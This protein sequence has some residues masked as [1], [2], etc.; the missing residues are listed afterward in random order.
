MKTKFHAAMG[1]VATLLVIVFLTSTLVSE[2]FLDHAVVINVKTMIVVA[3]ALLI[4]AMAAT[5]ASGISLAGGRAGPLVNVKKM[6]MKLL[7]A[8]GLLVMLPSAAFLY[9]RAAAGQ[10]DALFYG[11]QAIEIVGGCAQLAL[12]GLNLRDGFKLTKGK[13]ARPPES[14]ERGLTK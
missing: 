12:L 2:F 8:N 14:G 7:A 5:G 6:R 4:A 9:F 10:F 11:V 3:I 1:A 13:R